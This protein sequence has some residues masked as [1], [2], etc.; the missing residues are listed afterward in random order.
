MSLDDI[1]KS[2]K[3]TRGTGRGRGRGRGQTRGAGPTRRGR[4]RL[5]RDTPYT[6]VSISHFF[7]AALWPHFI[8]ILYSRFFERLVTF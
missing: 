4:G 2:G 7:V 8:I 6:R 1:I 5:N 3:K